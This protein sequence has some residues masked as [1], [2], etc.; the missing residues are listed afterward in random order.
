[1]ARI[2]KLNSP[3]K[4]LLAAD[5]DNELLVR[6]ALEQGC[7]GIY[8]Q[9]EQFMPALKVAGGGGVYCPHGVAGVMRRHSHAIVIDARTQR[10]LDVLQ[11]LMFGLADCQIS[12]R[13]VVSSDTVKTHNIYQKLAVDNRTKAAVT[14]LG[15]DLVTLESALDGALAD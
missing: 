12:E 11:G 7:G 15:A 14:A 3:A 13:L 2:E 9:S 10:E 5:D 8:I 1:V 4:T 6:E